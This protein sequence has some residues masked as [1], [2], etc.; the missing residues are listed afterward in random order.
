M[1][2]L[3][4]SIAV[5]TLIGVAGTGLGGA[6]CYIIAHPTK[7]TQAVMLSYSGGVMAAMVVFSMLPEAFV[8]KPF[9]P[10]ALSLLLSGAFVGALSAVLRLPADCPQTGEGMRLRLQRTSL[11]IISAIALHNLPEGLAIGTGLCVRSDYTFTL[12]LLM[13]LHDIPEGM[14]AGVGLK[15]GR[16]SAFKGIGACMLAGVP[17]GLGAA[18]GFFVGGIS[19]AFISASIAFAAGAM[20]LVTCLELIPSARGLDSRKC[21]LIP[22]FAAGVLTGALVI[23]GL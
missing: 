20:L 9:W 22:A 8:G 3:G 10:G 7:T 12:I 2:G 21:V 16:M 13:L 1:T 17:T 14:A 4:S 11:M 15:A 6:V 19:Q 18:V 23:A 5:G